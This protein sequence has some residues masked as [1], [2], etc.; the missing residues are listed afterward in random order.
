LAEGGVSR[1]NT[2]IVGTLRTRETTFWPTEGLVIRVKEGVLLLE[3]EPGFLFLDGIHHL[4]GVVTVVSPVWGAVV[5]VALGEDEDVV[6]AAEG[7]P[8]DSGWAKVDIGI[9]ARCLVGGGTIKVPDAEATDVFDLLG[10]GLGGKTPGTGHPKRRHTR[11]RRPVSP[12]S[13]NE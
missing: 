8:E 2:A 10:D 3:T 4:F 12:R 6:A 7:V 11:G 1:T 13:G 5:V 9:A